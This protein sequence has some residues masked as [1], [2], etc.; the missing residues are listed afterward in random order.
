MGAD[1]KLEEQT[2]IQAAVLICARVLQD[3]GMLKPE[4]E[5]KAEALAWEVVGEIRDAGLLAG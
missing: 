5:R 1:T 3:S 4:T 2:S